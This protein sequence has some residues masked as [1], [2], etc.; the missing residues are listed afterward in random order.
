[1]KPTLP[2]L[3]SVNGGF[4]DTAGFDWCSLVPPFIAF[5]TLWVRDPAPAARQ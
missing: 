2:V 5:Y 1:M 3:L 4:V